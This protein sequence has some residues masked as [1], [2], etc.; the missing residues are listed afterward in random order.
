MHKWLF[1]VTKSLHLNE[2]KTPM[3]INQEGFAHTPLADPVLIEIDNITF[4]GAKR[5]FEASAR[6]KGQLQRSTKVVSGRV[7]PNSYLAAQ[8]KAEPH[9]AK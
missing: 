1:I 9:P 8:D 5:I 7:E 2:T 6:F 4:T 3:H